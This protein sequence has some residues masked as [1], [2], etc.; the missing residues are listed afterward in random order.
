[1]DKIASS[2]HC[3]ILEYCLEGRTLE[4][5]D[6]H[7]DIS[8]DQIK[9]ILK[10]YT[11]DGNYMV[12]SSP[13]YITV[14]AGKQAITIYRENEKNEDRK[15]LRSSLNLTVAI[16]AVI[17]SAASLTYA[18]IAND[19]ANKLQIENTKTQATVEALLKHIATKD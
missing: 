18:A 16:V 6:N 4:A 5:I 10:E 7:F 19:R 1:M 3:E 12:F 13:N 11:R 8:Q 15:S 14:G 17:I 2:L 9:A